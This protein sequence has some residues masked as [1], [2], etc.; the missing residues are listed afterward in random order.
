MNA[1][2]ARRVAKFHASREDCTPFYHEHQYMPGVFARRVAK[3]HASREDCTPYMPGVW[4]GHFADDL[5]RVNGTRK[6]DEAEMDRIVAFL[7][8][9]HP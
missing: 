9:D 7:R 1:R 3:F 2:D 6:T 5:R 8:S 4:R